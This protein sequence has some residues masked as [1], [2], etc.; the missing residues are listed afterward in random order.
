V[1]V[2]PIAA[3]ILVAAVAALLVGR[4]GGSNGTPA[5]TA[6]E[7][8][9]RSATP[10]LQGHARVSAQPSV[11][12]DMVEPET[13]EPEAV[14]SSAEVITIHVHGRL[15][16][17]PGTPVGTATVEIAPLSDGGGSVSSTHADSSGEFDFP[18]LK[19]SG[20]DALVRVVVR[21]PGYA[22]DD[23]I[24]LPDATGDV[25]IEVRLRSTIPDLPAYD[26]RIVDESGKPIGGLPV[27]VREFH[28]FGTGPVVLGMPRSP[29]GTIGVRKAFAVTN[30]DGRFVA[31]GFGPDCWSVRISARDPAW[32]VLPDP[33]NRDW[34]RYAT[35]TLVAW[36]ALSVE[37]RVEDASG[38]PIRRFEV[39]S[40]P[41]GVGARTFAGRE[42]RFTLRWPV[43]SGSPP[44]CLDATVRADGYAP[45]SLSVP[46]PGPQE[47]PLTIR[48]RKA[49]GNGG[50]RFH[51]TGAGGEAFGTQLEER[52]LVVRFR[53]PGH[54][55]VADEE[56]VSISPADDSA[57]VGGL[58]PG[59]WEF[60]VAP[61]HAPHLAQRG[62]VVVAA[63]E[64]S[65][66]EVRFPS[67]GRIDLDAPR[68]SIERRLRGFRLTNRTDGSTL[69][70]EPYAR[71]FV[72]VG[73]WD[74]VAEAED[75]TEIGPIE[76]SVRAGLVSEV[77]LPASETK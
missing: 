53:R 5:T 58:E 54:L 33:L 26:A 49:E 37:L 14:D 50:V 1:R 76:V 35:R 3:V 24:G 13:D 27:E 55:S 66:V 68:E 51:V 64:V 65:E 60:E 31:R 46:I 2:L 15:I 32:I 28:F 6:H 16:A 18:P 73:E 40:A 30:E 48:L 72:P 62:S 74:L 75:G 69:R 19:W 42:G 11:S 17:P 52:E 67:F 56:D 25:R 43:R 71:G 61:L 4:G 45:E 47:E 70:I 77:E 39:S 59:S 44:A 9:P 36:P 21:L 10:R 23:E 20:S 22:E 29:D 34:T 57:G 7:E 38:A 63:H 8:R 41:E 12:T